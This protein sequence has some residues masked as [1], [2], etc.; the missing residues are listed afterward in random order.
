MRR[1]IAG[2]VACA[3]IAACGSPVPGPQPTAGR[4]GERTAAP[5]LEDPR[6][7]ADV[8]ASRGDFA[9]AVVRY[10][11][12]LRRTPDDVALR[13]ALAS[14]LSHLDRR[15]ETIEQFTWVLAHAP[16]GQPE[17]A[18]ARR[19]LRAAGELPAEP[20]VAGDS[21]ERHP[22]SDGA[23]TGVVR[24][25][26]DWPDVKPQEQR[27]PV[28][29]VLE[30]AGPGTEGQRVS[31]RSFVGEPYALPP[32]PRGAYRL[33][34]YGAGTKLWDAPLEVAADETVFDLTADK[35]PVPVGQFP[36][37]PVR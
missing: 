3:L 19:W 33:A 5:G 10:R 9:G 24:G 15:Q 12:A 2:V 34:A 28:R 32:V 18:S 27:V 25:K 29:V 11:Q 17:A 21:A 14:A 22:A 13:F 35:S 31:V 16:P 36:P 37:P 20:V 8:L 26:I 1:R 23:Q 30:G 4:P 7:E 6:R